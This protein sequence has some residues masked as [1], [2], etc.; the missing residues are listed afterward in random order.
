[1]LAKFLPLKTLRH[2]IETLIND[3]FKKF[4]KQFCASCKPAWSN[5]AT[6]KKF[7][8]SIKWQPRWQPR[9]DWHRILA[10][11]IDVNESRKT[12]KFQQCNV[13]LHRLRNLYLALTP[14]HLLGEV[15][16][17]LSH[18]TVCTVRY[19]QGSTFSQSQKTLVLLHNKIHFKEAFHMEK[20]YIE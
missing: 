11:A 19:H 7:F 2:L 5:K 15:Y 1:M 9:C 17:G 16:L 8:F 14:D 18:I 13:K 3:K 6:K 20:I 10:A 12:D 4:R